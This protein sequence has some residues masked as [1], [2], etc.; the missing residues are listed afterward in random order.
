MKLFGVIL[1]AGLLSLIV[2]FGIMLASEGLAPCRSDKA[3]CGLS[4]AYQVFL[5]PV[6]T[7]VVAIV[8]GLAL[9]SARRLNA[10]RRMALTLIL[11]PV[12]MLVLGLASDFYQGRSTQLADI[13]SLVQ[14][15]LPF[16]SIVL[17]Q[18][19]LLRGFV[20]QTEQRQSAGG[21]ING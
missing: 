7:V 19:L 11:V 2:G 8:M 21:A 18:W 3:G 20:L 16:C 9:L 10:I 12:F 13:L 15:A 17:V 1:V 14:T 5:V 4:S 6:E